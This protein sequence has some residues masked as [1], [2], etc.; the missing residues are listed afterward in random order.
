LPAASIVPII[1]S[2]PVTV[3]RLA[4]KELGWAT[5]KE[6]SV[7]MPPSGIEPETSGLWD[8]RCD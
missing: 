8:Q 4:K 2:S 1:W 3:F 6:T 5:K 7:L